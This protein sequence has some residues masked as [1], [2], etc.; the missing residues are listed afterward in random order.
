MCLISGMKGFSVHKAGP[1]IYS[2]PKG[3]NL[4]GRTG[5]ISRVEVKFVGM[6]KRARRA[7]FVGLAVLVIP[8]AVMGTDGMAQDSDSRS[9]RQGLKSVSLT[10]GSKTLQAVVADTDRS[11]RQGLLGAAA[12][13]DDE[14]M[15]LDFM[16]PGQYA[17]HMQGMRIPIDAIW[18]DAQGRIKLMYERIAPNSGQVY[19]SVFPCRYCLEVKAGLCYRYGVRV[20]Q[21][22]QFSGGRP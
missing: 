21:T 19:P 17:I 6:L 11:R 20:G 3:V 5:G 15:L 14:G 12:L 16:I 1:M 2:P 18:L 8:I 7:L 10:V 9:G 4:A 13:S 22:I